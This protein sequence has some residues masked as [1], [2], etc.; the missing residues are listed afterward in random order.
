MESIGTVLAAKTHKR[1]QKKIGVQKVPVANMRL[2]ALENYTPQPFACS[3]IRA[4]EFGLWNRSCYTEK[5]L[6]R[7][8][9]KEWRCQLNY[10]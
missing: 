4:T 5:C 1:A 10:H 8:K 9:R 6:L 3:A 2:G 7:R